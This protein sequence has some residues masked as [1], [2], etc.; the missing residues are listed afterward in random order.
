M[1]TIYLMTVYF[2][3]VKVT[4]GDRRKRIELMKSN[5][6]IKSTYLGWDILQIILSPI[7]VTEMIGDVLIQK[8]K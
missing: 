4:L 1:V 7:I 5:P 6:R 3:G 2:I 8:S